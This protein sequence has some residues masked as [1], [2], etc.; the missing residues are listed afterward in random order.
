[1]LAAQRLD[2]V[3]LALDLGERGLQSAG[4]AAA[5]RDVAPKAQDLAR[6]AHRREHLANRAELDALAGALEAGLVLDDATGCSAV[7]ARASAAWSAL[8]S[9]CDSS[10]RSVA[11][12]TRDASAPSH[13]RHAGLAQR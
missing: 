3:L 7:S 11:P 10:S 13:A 9:A 4:V 5:V 12:T 1:V 2:G 8:A 6:P